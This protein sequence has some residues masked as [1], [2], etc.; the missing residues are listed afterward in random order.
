MGPLVETAAP[1]GNEKIQLRSWTLHLVLMK[2]LISS[3]EQNTF[4]L[5]LLSCKRI[6]ERSL[7]TL[8]T[9]HRMQG[10]WSCK[11]H[12]PPTHDLWLRASCVT[13]CCDACSVTDRRTCEIIWDHFLESIMKAKSCLTSCHLDR[14]RTSSSFIIQSENVFNLHPAH[15]QTLL[16]THQLRKGWN[17]MRTLIKNKDFK[18]RCYPIERKHQMFKLKEMYFKM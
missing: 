10:L 15:Q 12:P 3:D 17:V 7:W 1:G 6:S 16:Y 8:S 2:N 9:T 18:P 14:S 5:Q 11:N 13:F 4:N